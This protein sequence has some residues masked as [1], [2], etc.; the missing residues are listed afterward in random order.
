VQNIGAY[1]VEAKDIIE[2]V[3]V[4][5]LEDGSYH[6]FSNSDCCYGYRDSKFKHE[7]K[8]KYAVVSVVYRLKQTFVPNLEYGNIA[9]AIPDDG[10]ELT[11]IRLRRAIIDI[12]KNK[13]PDPSVMGNAGSFFMNPVVERD[14]FENLKAQYPDIPSY[15][16]PN[17][18]VKIPAGWMIDKCGW[19]GKSLGKAGVYEKQALVLVNNGGATGEDIVALSNAVCQS[20]KE[21]FGIEIRPEVNFI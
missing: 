13:L 17:G 6:T 2:E 12:R 19:K 18:K 11:A 15:P 14:V 3:N 20:V 21:K 4:V 5:S 16:Q 7:W 8:G 9:S 1:G 10:R